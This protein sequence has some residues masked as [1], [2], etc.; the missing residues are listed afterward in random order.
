[1]TD[2][3]IRRWAKYG[4]DRGYAT[5]ADDT[6]LGWIDLKTGKVNH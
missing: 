3:T 1:M 5:A 6:K 2:I 4:H